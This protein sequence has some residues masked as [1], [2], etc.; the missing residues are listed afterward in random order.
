M[1]A[2]V[3]EHWG[4]QQQGKVMGPYIDVT[5]VANIMAVLGRI[6]MSSMIHT[7]RLCEIT[8]PVAVGAHVADGNT[9]DAFER[10]EVF[11]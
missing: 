7:W 3:W 5:V 11:E 1:K 8:V 4:P 9:P 6:K 10:V 2:A